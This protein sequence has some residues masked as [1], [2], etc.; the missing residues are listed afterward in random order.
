MSRR[1]EEG[2]KRPNDLDVF[3]NFFADFRV[4][5]QKLL[6]E[7]LIS[8]SPPVE[9]R[10]QLILISIVLPFEWMDGTDEKVAKG[11][12]RRPTSNVASQG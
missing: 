4:R 2:T 1:G 8:A 5:L 11:S 6:A 7:P 10:R 3:G 12:L 9:N